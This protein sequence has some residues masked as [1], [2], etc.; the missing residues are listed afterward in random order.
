MMVGGVGNPLGTGHRPMDSN[1]NSR[2][3]FKGIFIC[4]ILL[5]TI[6]LGG[7][8]G[9][10]EKVHAV[11]PVGALVFVAT[12][13]ATSYL[14]TGETTAGN[15]FKLTAVWAE[16]I[17]AERANFMSEFQL[18][19]MS[20]LLAEKQNLSLMTPAKRQQTLENWRVMNTFNLEPLIEQL[21]IRDRETKRLSQEAEKF[22]NAHPEIASMKILSSDQGISRGLNDRPKSDPDTSALPM[23]QRRP[24]PDL[25]KMQELLSQK[26]VAEK[27]LFQPEL[28]RI[29]D[30]LQ[31][32]GRGSFKP[33]LMDKK[34]QE[35]FEI[36][37]ALADQ[38]VI[39]AILF[40]SNSRKKGDSAAPVSMKQRRSN[41]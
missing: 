9:I 1:L 21:A 18:H 40:D 41:P 35:R 29:L 4:R 33:E 6:F 8:V 5:M 3:K 34:N 15:A 27:Q 38:R 39:P 22:R 31:T 20:A 17:K 37:A 30:I 11:G 23:N 16:Y 32:V 36:L 14:F 26:L 7:F 13:E 24:D 28:Q 25:V 12:D 10:P 2:I 19:Q